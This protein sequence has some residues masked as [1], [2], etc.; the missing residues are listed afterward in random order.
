MVELAR[1][2]GG[3]ALIVAAGGPCRFDV[4]Q[5]IADQAMSRRITVAAESGI[6]Q[7]QVKQRL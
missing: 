1:R 5:A 2:I 3:T 7:Q 4:R 6:A